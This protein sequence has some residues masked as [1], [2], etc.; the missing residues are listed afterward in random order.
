MSTVYVRHCPACGHENSSSI[1]RCRCGVLLTGIDL[2]QVNNIPAPISPQSVLP[3]ITA[4]PVDLICP[5]VDCAQ[6][7][8]AGLATCLYCNRSLHL[9]PPS[10]PLEGHSLLSLPSAL[11]AEYQIIQPLPTRGGEAELLLVR[12]MIGGPARVAKIYRH[13][14]RPKTD[15]QQRITNIDV[16]HRVEILSAGV[17]DGYAY[18]LMEFCESGS[19]R[20][21]FVAPFSAD[22]LEKLVDQINAAL[23]NVHK[24]GLLH[25]DLKPENIL[26]RSHDPLD[27]VLTD[28]GTASILDATQRFTSIAR[29]LRYAAPES[30]S[31]VLDA[32]TDYW[33]LGMIVLEAAIGHH[34]F[35]GLSEAVI[36]H[37]LTT[38]QIDLTPI[39]QPRLRNLL[40]GL[41]VRD[42]TQRWA[43]NEVNRWLAHD[44]TLI[45]PVEHHGASLMHAFHEPYHLGKDICYTT[46]Q[47]AAALTRNWRA[48][49]ADMSNG[50]LLTWFRDVQKDQNVVRLLLEQRQDTKKLVDLQLLE[51]IVFLAPGIPPVWQGESI[52]LS[53]ILVRANQALKGD[54]NAAQWLDNLYRYEPLAVYATAGNQGCANIIEKWKNAA[55]QFELA[56]QSGGSLIQERMRIIKPTAHVNFDEVVYG[57]HHLSRP[58][59]SHLHAYLLALAYDPQWVERFRQRLSPELTRLIPELPWLVELQESMLKNDM[60][61][62]VFETLLP[63]IKN[64][65]TQLLQANEE[66]RQ[67]ELEEL[68]TYKNDLKLII[69]TLRQNA[70]SSQWIPTYC[71]EI[72]NS[73]D[74]YFNLL[75]RI[76]SHGRVDLAWQDLRKSSA[77]P[78]RNASQILLLVDHLAERRAENLGWLSERVWAM[79]SLIF[80]V[81]LIFFGVRTIYPFFVAVT[82][83]LVWRM[84]PNIQM[85]KKIRVLVEKL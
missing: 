7:N 55:N 59:L 28:F 60:A 34:P 45:A 74:Q 16:A 36:L 46:E 80:I 77:R 82:S 8:P 10:V 26:L 48:G 61:L 67:L 47:L 11:K 85:V 31:G 49:V 23:A 63:T 57:G 68:I 51:L 53:A 21:M 38:R 66:Q 83:F 13:G 15:V 3:P 35:D 37:H 69:A 56:W 52:D 79:V 25:R 33:A 81:L 76:R 14:I 43:T 58:S 29:T 70:L 71:V 6:S 39:T 22:L 1:L 64:A 84:W 30:L 5:Y 18:E 73:L 62:L 2:V 78:E 17:S 75:A 19:L 9:P 65:A 41:L 40:Q 27:L 72:R 4:L 54:V 42:P 32:K 20:E 50:Q 12:A 44:A 24:A